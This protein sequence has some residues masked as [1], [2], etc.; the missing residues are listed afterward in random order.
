MNHNLESN[1]N[2]KSES[3]VSMLDLAIQTL[4]EAEIEIVAGA[5]PKYC[6]RI[7]PGARRS[8]NQVYEYDMCY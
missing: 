5:E 2:A 3:E 7:L 4:T 8:V 6:T 1:L